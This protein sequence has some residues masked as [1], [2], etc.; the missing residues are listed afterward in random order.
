[1]FKAMKEAGFSSIMFGI[2]SGSQ[3]VLDFYHKQTTPV[4]AKTAVA[5]AKAVGLQAIA[6]IIIG[7]PVE[8]L[9]DIEQTLSHISELDLDGLEVNALGVAPWD[10]LYLKAEQNGKT[11]Q[12]D[13]MRDHLISEYYDNLTKEELAKWVEQAYYAFFRIGLR[14]NIDK[15]IRYLKVSRD[16]RHAIMRNI[17][18]PYAWRLAKEHGRPRHKIEEILISGIELDFK[19]QIYTDKCIGFESYEKFG[20][21]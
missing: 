10:P 17:V 11:K 19:E 7:A 9:E 15:I 8:G 5:N 6:S 12:D 4:Q 14:R 1:M 18:N 2:E 3:K 21:S 16:A 20:T 13:W